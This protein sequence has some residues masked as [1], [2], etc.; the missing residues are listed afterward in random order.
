MWTNGQTGKR[1]NGQTVN[2]TKSPN[3]VHCITMKRCDQ[4]YP[5]QHI[6]YQL[7]N[8]F[9]IWMQTIIHYLL[10]FTLYTL[11]IRAARD[12]PYH[13][14]HECMQSRIFPVFS[15]FILPIKLIFG[16]IGHQFEL[17]DFA[18]VCVCVKN[19]EFYGHVS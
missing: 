10:L 11:I 1:A 4:M 18:R 19:Y 3:I 16:F 13:T 15:L 7:I 2:Q 14:P 9:I 6:D 8:G 12:I 17:C 5:C